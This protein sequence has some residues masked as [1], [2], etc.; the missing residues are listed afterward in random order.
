MFVFAEGKKTRQRK[1]V[2]TKLDY[3]NSI[4]AVLSSCGAIPVV[5]HEDAYL[6]LL[7]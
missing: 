3:D 1:T 6:I 4:V 7:K 5:L 2:K